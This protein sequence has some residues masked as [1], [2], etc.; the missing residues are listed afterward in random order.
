MADGDEKIDHNDR[1]LVLNRVTD[2]PTEAMWDGKPMVWK[3]GEVKSIQK[4]LAPHYVE[5]SVVLKDP[6]HENPPI[7][8]LVVVD[9]T[10]QP[11]GPGESAEP[12]TL[13][14]C[15]HLSRFGTIDTSNLP[16]ERMIGGKILV[17]DE[18]RAPTHREIRGTPKD[19]ARLPA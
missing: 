7:F 14:E 18:G 12:L 5:K 16:P 15:K 1:V 4:D 8:K 6:T 11:V 2:A 3:A 10:K 13:A 19:D 9:E 17:D